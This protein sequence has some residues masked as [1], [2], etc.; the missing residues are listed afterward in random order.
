MKRTAGSYARILV[1]TRSCAMAWQSRLRLQSGKFLCIPHG[2][3]I[4]RFSVVKPK[5]RSAGEG[6]VAT[7][8]GRLHPMKGFY[9][10][11]EAVEMLGD[12]RLRVLIAGT[13]PDE[14]VLA[15]RI[16]AANLESRVLLMGH[17][18]DVRSIHEQ[19]DCVV[20]P[21]VSHESFG[22]ALAEAMASGRPIITSDFGPFPEVNEDGVTGLVV[23]AGNSQMLAGALKRLMDDPGLCLRLG[24]AGRDRAERLYRRERMIDETLLLYGDLT[25]Q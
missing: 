11:V 17:V 12:P 10:L 13:G 19:S 16:R 4:S 1:P 23:P 15:E 7:A 14:A 18:E 25:T 3:D 8:I 21:S 22:L 24:V 2:I 20:L 5:R 9:H 6:F